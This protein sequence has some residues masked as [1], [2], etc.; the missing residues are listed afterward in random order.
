MKITNYNR[1]YQSWAQCT[2]HGTIYVTHDEAI[3]ILNRN[4]YNPYK[5]LNFPYFALG[6]TETKNICRIYK[7]RYK[8]NNYQFKII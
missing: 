4:I 7:L 8:E 6:I 2:I 1:G 5:T 3:E